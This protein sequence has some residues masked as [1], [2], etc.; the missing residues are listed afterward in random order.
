MEFY[1]SPPDSKSLQ[2]TISTMK[3]RYP[4]LHSFTA[5]KSVFGQKLTVLT[6]GN[7]HHVNFMIGGTH[8]TE[9][10]TTLLL[11]RF[12]ERVCDAVLQEKDLYATPLHRTLL[13]RGL[14][15]LPLLN[16]DGVDILCGR[17]DPAREYRG[18]SI[19]SCR[20]SWNANARGVD[21]NHNFDAGFA[22][23]KEAEQKAGIKG[24]AP[25][26]F[27]GT[28]P[29]SEPET[30]AVL[31]LCRGFDVKN[32]YSFHAQGEEFY[33]RY[34]SHTP[35]IS[36]YMAELFAHL[37]G[38]RASDA[39]GLA[40]HGG[41]KDWFIET[42]HRPGFTIEIGKGENPLPVSD[43]SA[44]EERLTETMTLMTLM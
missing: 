35:E 40:A 2:R 29:A 25:R 36:F 41:C 1:E 19:R 17:K 6:I 16:P 21:I 7:L 15:V 24:P 23:C 11:M 10:I 34:G 30:R 42:F 39:A 44:I 28:F 33:Y 3:Q 13:R 32:L 18:I 20:R 9:W 37:S 26:R 27:G 43:L 8:A 14:M 12:L 5:G 38:Y 31:H 22:L 4:F